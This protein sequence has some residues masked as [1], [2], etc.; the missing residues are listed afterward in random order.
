V[1]NFGQFGDDPSVVRDYDGD[2]KADV[3]VYR[4]GA[5]PGDQS[6]F[7]YRGTL[8]NPS[9][10]I[11]FIPWGIRGDVPTNGDFDG[12]GKGDFAVRRDASGAGVF[13][14]YK[15]NG[16]FDYVPFGYS[17][18]A[19]VPGDFDGDGKSDLAVA[20]VVGSNGNFYW[21]E[22]STGNV[23][24]PIVG[25]LPDSDQLA[26]GDYDGDGKS[27]IGLWRSTDGTFWILPTATFTWT[28]LQFGSPGDRAVG[29]WDVT[30]GN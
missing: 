22:S 25:G 21:R 24:G 19:I 1:E 16:T 7:F 10:G 30:G 2:G 8:N 5:N 17:T 28:Y 6:Y 4:Q 14:I 9:G 13:Y 27:D 20:R 29:E 15:A 12:D 3:A 23:V 11:T 18:D 26:I